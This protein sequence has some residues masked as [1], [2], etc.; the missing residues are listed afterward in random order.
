MQKL[1]EFTINNLSKAICGDSG[2]TPYLKGPELV[3]LFNQ[4]GYNEI[5]GAGF[6]SRWQYVEN[7]IRELNGK[8]YLI[9]LIEELVDPRRFLSFKSSVENA[10]KELNN[11]L[12][13]EKLE[14]VKVGDFFKLIGN[15]GNVVA[16]E[17][18]REINHAFI[19]QQITKCHKK[20][21][22]EDFNGAITNA[23]SLVEAVFIEI[24]ERHEKS[25]IKNDGDIDNLW[26]R[27]KKIM[28]LEVDR[29][30]MPDFVIQI[31]TGLE[32]S[33]KGLASLSNNAGDRHAN[34]FKT[35]KHH[36]KLAVNLAI[37]LAEFVIESWDYQFSR[38]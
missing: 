24:I 7:K 9:K 11:L 28:K 16:S 13:F 22:E 18:I 3:H 1:S 20:I 8:D 27:V 2:Y 33:L 19:N 15:T 5:Y 6:P 21:Q 31:L 34:K 12:K 36:S 37:T 10:V 29:E 38:K 23:R 4:F 32:T 25:T 17:S 30:S 14:L 35:Q 26:K